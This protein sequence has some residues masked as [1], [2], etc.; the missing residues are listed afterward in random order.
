M[1]HI[2]ELFVVGLIGA[3]IGAGTVVVLPQA[4]REPATVITVEPGSAPVH[5]VEPMMQRTDAE[6][7]DVLQKRL[8]DV[9][10]EQRQTIETLNA[11]TRDRRS[12]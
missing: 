9:A 8:A 5:R 2:T 3:A 10:A 11:V 12:Q 7:I 4:N 6:R 1:T